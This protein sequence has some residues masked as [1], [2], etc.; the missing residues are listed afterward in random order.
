M[1]DTNF[2]TAFCIEIIDA[3]DKLTAIICSRRIIVEFK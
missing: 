1:L 3:Y 2:V